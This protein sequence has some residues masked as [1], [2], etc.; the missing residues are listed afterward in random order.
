[1]HHC[2]MPRLGTL[3]LCAVLTVLTAT[4]YLPVWQ[5][6]FIDLDDDWYITAN[7][8]VSQ[9]LTREGTVWAWTTFHGKYWQ[10]LSWQ[11]LQFDAQFFSTQSPSGARILSPAAFHVHNLCWHLASVLVLF[12]LCLRMTGAL[13]RSFVVAAL[14]AVHPMRV[15]SVAW[16]AER[17]DVLHVFF[18]IA[19]LF[20]YV[21]YAE[22]RTIGR[23]AC[24]ALAMALGLLSKPMLMT[25]PFVLL[26][27]D[28]WPLGRSN[29]PP[30]NLPDTLVVNNR[31]PCNWRWLAL[32]KLP[33]FGLAALSAAITVVARMHTQAAV[34]LSELSLSARLA[35]ALTAYG[36]Y[37]FNTI[38]PL[39]LAVMYPHPAENWSALATLAGAGVVLAISVLSL[40]NRGRWPWLIVGWTWFLITLT[41]VIGFAQGGPQARA[42]RFCYFPHIGLLV[43]FVWQASV[44]VQ[45]LRIPASVGGVVAAA[46]VACLAALTWIQLG[47]WHDT[48][49][50]WERALAVTERNAEA[51]EHLGKYY[52]SRGQLDLAESHFAE[53]AR[54]EPRSP[55]H[56]RL[57][58]VTRLDLGKADDA[59]PD[60]QQFLEQHPGDLQC[61]MQ[62]GEAYLQTEQPGSAVNCFR[63]VLD[64]RPNSARVLAG[65][66]RALWRAG[67]REEAV[68]AFHAAVNL[69]PDLAAAWHGLALAELAEGGPSKAAATLA[70]ALRFDPDDPAVHADRAIALGRCGNWVDAVSEAE[71]A[72][73]DQAR[74]DERLARMGGRPPEADSVRLLVLFNCRL[75]YCINESG[76]RSAGAE[77]YGRAL[78]LDPNWPRKL[79]ARARLLATAA[80]ANLRDPRLAYELASQA[81]QASGD[82]GAEMLDVLAAAQAAL[83]QFPEAARTAQQA[84]DKAAATAQ[85]ALVDAIQ[86]RL[87]LYKEGRTSAPT[88][89]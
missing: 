34:P 68:K 24:V 73:H 58:A 29:S 61:R 31:V 33:L 22:K 83:G 35:N 82:P 50:L 27:L 87:L 65:F 7:P 85:P 8:Q 44:L 12:A 11:A 55:E 3:P 43:A 39:D 72:V 20:A 32:E 37:L 66:G 15:E 64:L 79:T 89:R 75:G 23:Y 84:V 18:G 28:Y 14:F 51:H 2:V 88:K 76:D 60:L 49:T 52:L 10:P 71:T 16:A 77:T 53:A 40:R 38:Y 25:L 41:P 1:M 48:E 4:A 56:R 59:T 6:G 63:K 19:T 17:K 36:A 81:I 54:I 80:D 74:I 45:R 78:K 62:L 46:A 70:T 21:R 57:L 47:F 42:D 9:G 69:E 13:G 67:R 30:E 86:A 26:L 5:N